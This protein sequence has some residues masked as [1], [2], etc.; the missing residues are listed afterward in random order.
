VNAASLQ[1]QA[2]R[3]VACGLCLPAC[4]TYRKT[5]SE[6]DSP[7]GRVMLVRGLFEG[8]LDPGPNLV[9]HLDRCLA[10]RACEAVC[11]SGVKYGELI[12]GAR[13]EL[14]RAGHRPTGLARWL[15]GV[16]ASPLLLGLAGRVRF[17]ACYPARGARRGTVSLFLGCVSRLI[18]ISGVRPLLSTSPL[19]EFRHDPPASP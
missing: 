6:A 13:A 12:D 3:C 18:D 9:E 2:N 5:E 10:C 14:A 19:L 1:Q 15:P 8:A 17:R 16:L 11:P 4:P 7:R